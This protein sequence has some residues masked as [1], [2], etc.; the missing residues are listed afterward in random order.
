MFR[1]LETRV[2]RGESLYTYTRPRKQL[3]EC[4]HGILSVATST[5]SMLQ[6]YDM[7]IY[8]DIMPYTMT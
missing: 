5:H 8:H 7:A 4:T 3:P 2:F 1:E 6:Y